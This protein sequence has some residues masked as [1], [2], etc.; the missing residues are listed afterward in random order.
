MEHLELLDDIKQCSVKDGQCVLWWLGQLGFVAKFRTATVYLDPFLTPLPRRLIPSPISPEEAR[1]DLILGSHDHLD[2]IDREAWPAIARNNPDAFFVVP[3]AVAKTVAEKT[4]IA[5]G[6]FVGLNPGLPA[7]LHGIR[8]TAVPAAHEFLDRDPETG[9]YPYLGY[10]LEAGGCCIYHS[11]DTCRYEGMEALLRK[12]RFDAVILPINGRDASRLERG[13][14]GNMTYQETA[15]L[16]G[17]LAPALT[18]CGH[19]DMFENNLGD[20][21]AFVDYMR[22]KYPSVKTLVPRYGERIVLAD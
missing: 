2:H 14:I 11:G 7:T 21:Q 9:L 1:A 12:Y 10:I 17:T 13:C 6:R 8:I 19:F 4:G 3:L 20:P 22:V 16:A 18:I 15:D 5:A